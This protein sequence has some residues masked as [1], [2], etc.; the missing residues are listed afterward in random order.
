MTNESR[1][2]QT[3]VTAPERASQVPGPSARLTLPVLAWTFLKIGATAFGETELALIERELVERRAVLTHADLT[4]ALTYTKPLPGST[5]LQLVAYLAYK[6][7][8]WTGSAVATIAYALPAAT[9]MALLAA[10]YVAVSAMP[11]VQPAINGLTAAA[12]GI[13]LATTHRLAK[14]NLDPRQP[15]TLALALAAFL[16]GAVLGVNAA[17]IVVVAGLAGVLFLSPK[18]AGGETKTGSPGS[19]GPVKTIGSAVGGESVRP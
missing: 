15:L 7:G 5:V 3:Q 8:G 13:L 12:V 19:A 14:R 11:G 17:L 6:A 2:A 9:A 16:A 1:A 18:T 10:G 4:E